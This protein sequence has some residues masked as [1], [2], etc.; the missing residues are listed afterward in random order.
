MSVAEG[1]K[2]GKMTTGKIIDQ[3]EKETSISA[4]AKKRGRLE[5]K[6][7]I[8]TG[9]A[10]RA[11]GVGNGKAVAKLFA[12]E[13][14]KV[15]LVNRSEEHAN[16]LRDE[17][18]EEGGSASVY[19]ADIANAGQVQQMAAAAF[20]RYGSVD[21]L[22]NNVGIGAPGTVETI[23]D[24][25]WDE[26]VTV[27]LKGTMLCC[28][29]AIPY[30]KKNGGGSIVNV[31]T[32]AAAIGLKR[33]A[34]AV[35]YSASKAGIHGLTLSLAADYAAFGIRANGI[36]VGFVNTPMV[37]LGE[38]E[39]E[40][41]RLGTPLL[42]EGSAWDVAYAALYLASDESRWVTGAFLPVDGGYST[43]REWLR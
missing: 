39:R 24:E 28:K 34:G 23:S 17:I 19:A 31:S 1:N 30:M 32:I 36:I 27:N 5:G 14:A 29:Y 3:T 20:S 2:G 22:H 8:V 11:P 6:V 7:A 38:E 26:I 25:K 10:S 15:L 33:E 37:A 12:R 18:I 42:T 40:R 9:A 13:G 43:V 35:A 16:E 41:R 21:I 4:A